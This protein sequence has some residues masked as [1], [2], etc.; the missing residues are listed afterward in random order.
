MERVRGRVA[1][2]VV[3]FLSVAAGC[4]TCEREPQGD[5]ASTRVE[6][7]PADGL[8]A[9]TP[10]QASQV[11]ATVGERS[12]TLG[13]YAAVLEGM[14]P[15]ER[16]R[17][18][19]ADRRKALLDELINVELL[20]QEAERRGLKDSAEYRMRVDQML[21]EHV[22]RRVR[23]TAPKVDDIP[24]G[25]VRRYYAE[26][27]SEFREPERRRLAHIV[28]Q[29]RADAARVLK[30][31]RVATPAQ[32]G[33]LVR[34]HSLDGTRWGEDV[35]GELAGDLGIV[36]ARAEGDAPE[37]DQKLRDALFAIEGIGDVFPE[38]VD[39]QAGF[40][41]IRLIGRTEARIRPFEEAE[42][43]IRVAMVRQKVREAETEMEK[44]LR[45]RYPVEIDEAALAEVRVPA[46]A[47][48]GELTGP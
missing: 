13:E 11:L 10:E 23:E 38:L 48:S 12:I 18:R 29:T 8:S 27:R 15:F 20:A 31:A 3:V 47:P 43:A 5:T 24:M 2:A 45:K 33:S 32:W 22:L 41:I 34:Q 35:P 28:M 26:N 6:A 42:R 39:T 37:V 44:T 1:A 7:G 40:H 4:S 17:F 30:Q 46:P 36:T 21:R 14:N 19:A 16:M 25:E 9:L